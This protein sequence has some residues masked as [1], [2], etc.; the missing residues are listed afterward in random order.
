MS[1]KIRNPYRRLTLVVFVIMLIALPTGS[2]RADPPLPLPRMPICGDQD[3]SET[4]L[5]FRCPSLAVTA[6]VQTYRVHGNGEVNVSFDFVFREATYN[7]ELGFFPV[8]DPTGRIGDLNPG[9]SGYLSTALDRAQIIFPSGST[10]A[11]P[12]VTTKLAAGTVVVFFIIQNNAL[13]NFKAANPNNEISKLPLA[14]FSLDPL[15]PDARDHFV[16]FVGLDGKITQFGFEDITNGGDNDY[17]DIVYNVN[18]PLPPLL[19]DDDQD[20]L[21]NDWETAGVDTNGDGAKDLF[22]DQL[23]EV[24]EN[25]DPNPRHKDIYVWIDWFVAGDHSHKPSDDA[26]LK[27][28]QAFAEAPISQLN[29]DGQPGINLHLVF[30]WAIAET[31][32]LVELGSL[33]VNSAGDLDYD[34]SELAYLKNR[35][36]QDNGARD[37]MAGVFHYAV[38]GHHLPEWK[39]ECPDRTGRPSGI[40]PMVGSG[41]GSDFIVSHQRLLEWG[42]TGERFELVVGGTF[43]HELGHALDLGHGGP[44][45]LNDVNFK[46]NHISVMNYSFTSGI[47]HKT[48]F[49]SRPNPS[50]LDYSRFG[51]DVLPDLNENALNETVGM[52]TAEALKDYGSVYYRGYSDESGT[53][54]YDLRDHINWNGIGP[55]DNTVVA[56]I[57]SDDDETQPGCQEKYSVLVSANEWV[58]L[59][60]TTGQIGTVAALIQEY[61]SLTTIDVSNVD[62]AED[63]LNVTDGPSTIYVPTIT[64]SFQNP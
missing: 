22:L 13:A 43:M 8:D 57:N 59:N 53:P 27:V 14:F 39:Q 34:S 44:G 48:G 31:P 7:N 20:G 64:S 3:G 46:P 54:I 12:D 21:P 60:Y 24:G 40:A 52:T 16:G 45:I 23:D 19:I 47:F 28:K 5:T 9:E 18:P 11:T 26:L 1:N 41:A 37:G 58:A 49:F 4:P 42:V 36:L 15:N 35:F 51:P 38:F 63:I 25:I 62:L 10:A 6:D 17:D 2:V 55:Y 30:G 32:D 61:P 50:R 56:N 29:P 33:T